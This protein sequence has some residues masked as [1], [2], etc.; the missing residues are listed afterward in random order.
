MVAN[1]GKCTFVSKDT[2]IIDC[3]NSEERDYKLMD[4]KGN[5]LI[6]NAWYLEEL[7]SGYIL[8]AKD[9]NK[10]GVVDNHGFEII[11]PLY[12]GLT[13]IREKSVKDELQ[14]CRL[15]M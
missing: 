13:V 7:S 2:F 15:F 3:S 12:N 5:V 10:I 14:K 8:Y 1:D 11:R 4:I 9:Y 6:D